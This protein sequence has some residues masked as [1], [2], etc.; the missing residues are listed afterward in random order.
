M[1]QETG[2]GHPAPTR[3]GH[4]PAE[5][6]VEALA[7]AAAAIG[8][9]FLVGVS[10][11]VTASILGRWLFRSPINGD[12]ELVQVGIAIAAFLFLPLC[13]LH[14]ENIIVDAFT[15][16]A[17]KWA[18]SALDA[19]WALVYAMVAAFL[20]WRLAVG[21]ADT[22]RSGMTTPM[23]QLPYAWAMVVGAAALGFLALASLLVSIRHARDAGR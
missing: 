20:A 5:R 3:P 7:Y 17:P 15:T 11:L 13:Q 14:N 1:T 18:V 9:L 16:R 8:G 23:L 10:L 19:F 21:A 2:V 22:M 6:L 12:Y 4:G